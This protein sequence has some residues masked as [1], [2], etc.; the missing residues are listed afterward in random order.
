MLDTP[1]L[2][3]I[4]PRGIEARLGLVST[5]AGALFHRDVRVFVSSQGRMALGSAD[6]S[7]RTVVSLS[8]AAQREG[9][10]AS[11]ALRLFKNKVQRIEVYLLWPCWVLQLLSAIPSCQ[12]VSVS[13]GDSL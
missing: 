13:P 4:L 5:G 6:K 2:I 9:A 11:E 3:I 1:R 10:C 8:R 7:A 12:Q